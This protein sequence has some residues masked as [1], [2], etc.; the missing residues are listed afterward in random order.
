MRLHR[1]VLATLALALVLPAVAEAQGYVYRVQRRGL[2]GFASE[3]VVGRDGQVRRVV[4]DVV[5]DS[6]A[7]KAGVMVGDTVIRFNGLAPRQELLS[8]F[9]PG[10]TVVLRLRRGG[11]ERNLS[12]VAAERTETFER[13]YGVLPDSIRKSIAIMVDRVRSAEMDTV[14]FPRLRIE[15]RSGDSTFVYLGPDRVFS[16]PQGFKGE[17]HVDSI[18]K[19]MQ[20]PRDMHFFGDSARIRIWTDT[21]FGRAGG[22]GGVFRWQRGDSSGFHFFTPG[23]VDRVFKF[24]GDST[25]TFFRPGDIVAGSFTM[26]MRAIAGAE[27]YELN[28][29]LGEALGTREGVLVLNAAEGTPAQRSGLRAGDVIVTAAGRPVTSIAALRNVVERARPGST[30]RLEVL[31]HGNRTNIELQRQ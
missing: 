12:V 20:W 10:D 16:I 24:G 8:A 29:S 28:P 13:T 15:K 11:R 6:P 1:I 27:L 18:R 7:E 17:I 25:T 4:V 22:A 21:V 23:A 19:L 2:L 31:R 26:G 14:M 9:E 3:E 30:V 5:K